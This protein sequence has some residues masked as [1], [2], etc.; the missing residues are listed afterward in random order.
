[1]ARLRAKIGEAG[2]DEGVLRAVLGLPQPEAFF[3]ARAADSD[4]SR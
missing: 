1:M 3:D 4:P 2:D